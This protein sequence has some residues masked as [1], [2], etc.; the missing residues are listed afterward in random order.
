[1]TLENSPCLGTFEK[2]AGSSA[3][4]A[5]LVSALAA[6]QHEGDLVD[7][8]CDIVQDIQ[9][10]LIH[11]AQQVAEEVSEGVNRPAHNHN[12]AHVVEG[13]LDGLGALASHTTCFAH[14]DLLEDVEPAKHAEDEAD[15]CFQGTS[16]PHVA[17]GQ[18]GD[19][20]EQQTPEHSRCHGLVRCL[21]D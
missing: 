4:P 10:S 18:H 8:I 17:E 5:Y 20:A 1:M 12:E 15:P 2:R 3:C 14:E 16:L 6:D 7:E 21:Q 19:S 13:F 11:C 9:E